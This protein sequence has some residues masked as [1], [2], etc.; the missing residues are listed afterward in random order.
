MPRIGI[1]GGTFDPPHTGHA[2]AARAVLEQLDL[3]RL[4]LMV[5]NDPWQKSPTRT[6]TPAADRLAMTT[7]MAE[8]IPGAAVSGLEIDRGG[9]TYSIDTVE[10]DSPRHARG[11]RTRADHFLDRRR[12]P[13]E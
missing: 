4:W 6:I 10:A 11:R 7:A 1:F 13:R 2:A 12:R 3:D 8:S 5:A 9:A